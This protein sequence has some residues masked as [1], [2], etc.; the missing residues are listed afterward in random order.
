MS[1]ATG[2]PVLSDSAFSFLSCAFFKKRAV[3]FMEHIIA[4]RHIYGNRT[5]REP[6]A[7]IFTAH[8]FDVSLRIQFDI[9]LHWVSNGPDLRPT[10]SKISTIKETA[11]KKTLM[12]C[13][14]GLLSLGSAAWAQAQKTGGI[15][16]VVA[17][18]EQ[19]WLQS[20]KTNN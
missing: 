6:R 10:F 20:Q 3:R 4:Y 2:A 15:E 5:P 11:M 14:I 9:F 19:Q 18:L 17:A 8:G 7:T 12:W 1:S 16:K 13:L